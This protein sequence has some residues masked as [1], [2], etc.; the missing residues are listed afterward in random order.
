MEDF[1]P[2]SREIA[3]LILKQSRQ[4][5]ILFY[6]LFKTCVVCAYLWKVKTIN[7]ALNPTSNLLAILT[8]L[9]VRKFRKPTNLCVNAEGL[10]RVLLKNLFVDMFV[11][12]IDFNFFI[13]FCWGVAHSYG[14][15]LVNWDLPC[16]YCIREL[17]IRQSITAESLN[18]FCTPQSRQWGM[19]S[20]NNK[21]N[22]KK[23]INLENEV[24]YCFFRQC[25]F[26]L[27]Y[28]SV[29]HI[30]E[31]SIYLFV[32]TYNKKKKQACSKQALFMFTLQKSSSC[33]RIQLYALFNS[34]VQM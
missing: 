2:S 28:G 14:R 20:K 18:W 27:Q 13:C 4:S 1:S 6:H 31:K 26:I 33:L 3:L 8:L 22:N 10:G 21:N 5:L 19:R 24:C 32:H 16:M 25:Y 7:Q 34:A 30:K 12:S 15:R 17:L 11:L 9:R 29:F 23:I